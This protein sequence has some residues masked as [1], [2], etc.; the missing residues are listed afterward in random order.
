[1]PISAW[2]IYRLGGWRALRDLLYGAHLYQLPAGASPR[3]Y[4]RDTLVQP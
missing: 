4:K 1:M 3:C 2:L